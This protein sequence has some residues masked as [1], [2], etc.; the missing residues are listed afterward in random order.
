[1]VEQ[2]SDLLPETPRKLKALLRNL[3]TLAPLI[4]RH[5]PAEVQWTDLLLGQLI[6]L[7][8]P[9]FMENFL[10]N[11]NDGLVQ[12][13]AYLPP[14][15]DEPLFQEKIDNAVALSGVLGDAVRTRVTKVL[16]AWSERRA[17]MGSKNFSYYATFG[18][19]HREITY[20]EFEALVSVYGSHHDRTALDTQLI[21]HARLVTSPIPDVVEEFLQLAVETRSERLEMAADAERESETTEF[22]SKA[23]ALAD[24]VGAIL[25]TP[26][27]PFD[28]KP[29]F[30]RTVV[31][32]LVAQVL[33]WIHFDRGVHM[34]ARQQDRAMLIA[35]ANQDILNGLDWLEFLT[36][37]RD[38]TLYGSAEGKIAGAKLISDLICLVQDR[39]K[40]EALQLFSKAR[41]PL[42]FDGP[43]VTAAVR[44][45][46]FDPQSPLWLRSGLQ[47]FFDVL[48]TADRNVKVWENASELLARLSWSRPRAG[49]GG[50]KEGWQ[51][52]LRLPGVARAL[53]LASTAQR[54]HY[55]YQK[56]L[57]ETRIALLEIK[58]PADQLQIPEWLTERER[59][60]SSHVDA[61]ESTTND[62]DVSQ[63]DTSGMPL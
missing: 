2:N 43:K 15:K 26:T 30:K 23:G 3:L 24:L 62:Q 50:N 46:F 36:P 47:Q 9:G 49:S 34:K 18:S 54:L 40:E 29:A 63:A 42:Q 61:T 28:L 16:V 7:E 38:S 58:I 13:G 12:V 60:L 53:W 48:A 17:L 20:R 39:V 10:K 1:M 8:A 41:L 37:W 6:R 21:E 57:L 51:D 55:R 5:D 31:E 32:S 56:Q 11:G 45:C 25:A 4:K 35:L 14:R 27:P 19:T 44:F 59:E 33:R 22:L 52:I